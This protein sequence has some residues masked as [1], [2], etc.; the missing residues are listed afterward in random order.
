MTVVAGVAARNVCR[1]LSGGNDAVVTRAT[2]S[3]Y[4]GMIDGKH[5]GENIRVVAVLADIRCLNVCRVFA[6]RVR[7]VMAAGTVTGDIDV[8]EIRG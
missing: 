7:A 6:G 3:D 2:I 4:L 1:V 5:R 8:V